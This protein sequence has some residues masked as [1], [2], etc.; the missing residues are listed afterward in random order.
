[1]V[2]RISQCYMETV[3]SVHSLDLRNMW[4]YILV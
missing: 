1:M 2:I 3:F 4:I